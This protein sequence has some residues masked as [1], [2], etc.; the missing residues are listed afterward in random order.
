MSQELC[1]VIRL[2]AG[3]GE[4]EDSVS[5]KNKVLSSLLSS[6]AR[7]LVEMLMSRKQPKA[8]QTESQPADI[9]LAVTRTGSKMDAKG[10]HLSVASSGFKCSW[11]E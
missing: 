8:G 4:K 5:E 9:Y 1:A 10:R 11:G 2:R 3:V 7:P 6:P